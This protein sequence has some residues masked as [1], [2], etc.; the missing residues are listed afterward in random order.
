MMLSHQEISTPNRPAKR[1][2]MSAVYAYIEL[3]Q[4]IGIFF[5]FLF[6]LLW[7]KSDI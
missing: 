1:M 4:P 2:A 5:S 7:L 6:L 3:C